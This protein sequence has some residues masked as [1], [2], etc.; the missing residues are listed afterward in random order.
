[1]NNLKDSIKQRIV[2]KLSSAGFEK[3][4]NLSPVDFSGLSIPVMEVLERTNDFPVLIDVPLSA[5]R[6][7]GMLAFSCDENSPHPFIR[8]IREYLDGKT[9]S[10]H[11]SSLQRY[12]ECFQPS[13]TADYLGITEKNRH[14]SFGY[15]PLQAIEPWGGVISK[16]EE[17]RKIRVM[18]EEGAANGIE[19]NKSEWSFIGPISYERGEME[20]KRLTAIADSIMTHGY[21]RSGQK[22]GDITGKLLF[23]GND[24]AVLI[25]AGQHRISALA[26]GGYSRAPIVV[27]PS[28][29]S[30]ARREQAPGWPGVMSGQFSIDQAQSIFDRV[31]DGLQPQAYVQSCL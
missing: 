9:T 26:A 2:K 11:G 18:R 23:R 14:E 15:S 1:M 10:Y 21:I 6:G 13:T 16:Q 7:M 22:D 24:Y 12:Y 28:R 3:K 29:F 30:V 4:A 8:T 25:G 19:S 20:F 27:R 5:C 17:L 31:F